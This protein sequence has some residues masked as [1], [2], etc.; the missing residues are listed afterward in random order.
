MSNIKKAYAE[1]F[2]ILEANK[3]KKVSTVMPQLMELMTAKQ[4][5]KN[6]I[7]NDAGE[8]THVYCYYHK[9]WEDVT[10]A[11]FG[12]K[13]STATGLKRK[14]KEGVS[15]WTKAQKAKKDAKA[16]LLEDVAKGLVEVSEVATKMVEID[17]QATEIIPRADGHQVDIDSIHTA[18]N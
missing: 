10:V 8:V 4:N 15:Q 6:F 9:E 1:I 2:A 14:C 16:K 12:A 5:S 11:E 7:T 18:N 3:N 13:K 17:T